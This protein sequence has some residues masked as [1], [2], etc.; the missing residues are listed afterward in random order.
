MPFR[1]KADDETRTDHQPSAEVPHRTDLHFIAATCV[2]IA[3]QQ[4]VEPLCEGQGDTLAHRALRIDSAHE[5]LCWAIENV[6]SGKLNHETP[7]GPDEH[8]YAF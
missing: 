2:D 6:S 3:V 7:P 1:G 8:M 4:P 5:R